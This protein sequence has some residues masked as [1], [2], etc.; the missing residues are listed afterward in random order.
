MP[1]IDEARG[2]S[3]T[4]SKELIERLLEKGKEALEW[5][6]SDEGGWGHGDAC[7]I[8]ILFNEAAAHITAQEARV[9]V[10]EGERDAVEAL[11]EASQNEHTI[12]LAT[13][14]QQL[15]D[16]A[17]TISTLRAD[18][19]KAVEENGLLSAGSCDVEGGK[20][21]DERG[22]AYCT[23]QLKL[24]KAVEGL[25]WIEKTCREEIPLEYNDGMRK[26][27]QRNI[28]DAAQSFIKELKP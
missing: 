4:D 3:M 27:F 19:A 26:V 7:E 24:A 12:Q 20:L 15:D 1:T 22:N 18:L 9:E 25:E 6:T 2:N 23:L 10:L 11:L 5:I 28:R 13:G 14:Q 8:D 16:L 17:N 21:G